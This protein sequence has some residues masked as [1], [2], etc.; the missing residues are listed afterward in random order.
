MTQ[1]NDVTNDN[2]KQSMSVQQALERLQKVR[3]NIIKRSISEPLPKHEQELLEKVVRQEAE[4]L[5][6]LPTMLIYENRHEP[7]IERKIQE[8]GNIKKRFLKGRTQQELPF[9]E[10]RLFQRIQKLEQKIIEEHL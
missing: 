7:F 6:N 8:L 2:T 1:Q 10:R 3:I 4:L 9:D 5:T